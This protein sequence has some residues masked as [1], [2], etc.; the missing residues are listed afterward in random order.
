MV[1]LGD[2]RLADPFTINCAAPGKGRWADGRNWVYD[3]D[4]DLPAGL[5]CTF[6]LKP[7]L[8]ALDGRAVSGTDDVQLQH[9]RPRHP[10]LIP[11]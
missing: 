2:P 1:A 4:A 5:R 10:R 11:V 3:F 7:N 9:R 8:E 6:R